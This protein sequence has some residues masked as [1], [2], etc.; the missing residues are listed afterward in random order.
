MK[1]I[2]IPSENGEL[3]LTVTGRSNDS[4]YDVEVHAQ[5][6]RFEARHG[7]CLMSDDFVWLYDKLVTLQNEREAYLKNEPTKKAVFVATEEELGITVYYSTEELGKIV[8]ECCIQS[9]YTGTSLTF[10]LKT[11]LDD[12]DVIISQVK[13]VIDHLS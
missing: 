8:W 6:Q 2:T 4:W 13:D 5:V 9:M 3:S 7:I 10:S 1:N 11:Y 12:L